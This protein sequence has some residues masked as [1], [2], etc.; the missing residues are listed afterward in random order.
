MMVMS[1]RVL[2]QMKIEQVGS[3]H[4]SK[5]VRALGIINASRDKPLTLVAPR[6]T[7][8]LPSILVGEIGPADAEGATAPETLR[9]MDHEGRQLWKVGR[10]GS[11]GPASPTR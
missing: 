6:D 10:T 4:R 3:L 7:H 9:Q 5:M 1:F 8:S 2:G 11:S